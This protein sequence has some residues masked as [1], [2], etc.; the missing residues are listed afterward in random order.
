MVSTVIGVAQRA[1]RRW[2]HLDVGAFNGVMEAL[3]TG[4]R[5]RYPIEDSRCSAARTRFDLTGPTCDSQDTVLF[6]VPMSADLAV[7]DRV[8]IAVAGA[9]TTAY[10]SGFNGFDVP[11]VHYV[12]G[13]SVVTQSSLTGDAAS[14]CV[15]AVS[16][17]GRVPVDP[18]PPRHVVRRGHP[19]PRS[20][21]HPSGVERLDGR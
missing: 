21:G 1:G 20:G 4:N 2:A 7:G 13:R 9:Y 10:A 18:E 5:L 8:R 14:W 16:A 6:D 17:D 12:G 11:S 19:D 15:P 3:E